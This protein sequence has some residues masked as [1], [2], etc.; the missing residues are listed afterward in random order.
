MKHSHPHFGKDSDNLHHQK[1]NMQNLNI[2]RFT[3]KKR[4]AMTN[5]RK[6]I[7]DPGREV[8]VL[9]QSGLTGRCCSLSIS[10]CRKNSFK[11]LSAH[12]QNKSELSKNNLKYFSE[13]VRGLTGFEISAQWSN[14]ANRN[15]LSSGDSNSTVLMLFSCWISEEWSS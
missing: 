8:E 2:L 15:I 9:S 4:G 5:S 12:L 10:P 11:T 1:S 14:N 13:M 7:W 3:W 6:L